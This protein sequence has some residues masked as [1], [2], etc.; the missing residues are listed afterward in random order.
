M[1][2]GTN[3]SGWQVQPN[4]TSIQQIVQESI[5]IVLH[6]SV[7]LIGSGRTDAGVHALDQVAHFRSNQEIDL[8][9]FSRSINGILPKD[10]RLTKAL[11]APNDFHAQRS[12]TSKEY[13]YILCLGP[14]QPPFERD[15]SLHIPFEVDVDLLQ[16][17]ANYFVGTH[18]FT[19]FAN[20]ATEGAASKNAVRTIYRIDVV[21]WQYGVRLEFEGSGFLYKMVRNIVGTLLAICAGKRQLEEIPF[22]FEAKDR[23][24]S[25]MGAKASG[26]FLVKVSY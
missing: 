13:H 12:A 22:L 3:Y 26:L 15:Y 4:A 17:A 5:Q 1:Y 6:E 25:P 7:S 9:R 8:V 11:L 20:K 23:R 18:D 14:I 2:D 21:P 19:S 16:R 24:L 10:I